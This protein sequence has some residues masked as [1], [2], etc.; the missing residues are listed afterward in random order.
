MKKFQF[1]LDRVL[2]YRQRILEGRQNEYATATRRVQEQQARLDAVQERYQSLNNRFREE[3]AAGITIADAMSYENGLRVLERE[4]ARET[5]TL[6]RLEQEAKEKRQRM[7]Q[8]YMDATVLERLKEKQRDAYE[9]EVQKRDE[10]FIEE[11]VSAAR[12]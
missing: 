3:A 8:A 7:L 6:Q 5:Q 10:Q 11:L 4:I 2:D 12:L 9:K 1:G